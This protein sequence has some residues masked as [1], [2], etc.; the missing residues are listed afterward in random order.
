M[1]RINCVCGLV[2]EAVDDD[3]LVKQVREHLRLDHADLVGNV[4][5]QDILAQAEQD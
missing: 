2:I 3:E 4:T 1:K 5:R